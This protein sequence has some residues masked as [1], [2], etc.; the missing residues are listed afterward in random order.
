VVEDRVPVWL[1]M[2]DLAASLDAA[3]DARQRVDDERA[4][5]ADRAELDGDTDG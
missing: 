2:V 5:M 1:E 3:R 4:L